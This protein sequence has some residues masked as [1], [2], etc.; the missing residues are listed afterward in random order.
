ML[1]PVLSKPL[2]VLLP[3]S[4]REPAPK[5]VAPRP[6]KLKSRV[7]VAAVETIEPEPSTNVPP[8]KPTEPPPM[9]LMK[10]VELPNWACVAAMSVPF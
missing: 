1:L 5:L 8:A 9:T 10:P 7:K 6:D 2:K 4:C 3:I